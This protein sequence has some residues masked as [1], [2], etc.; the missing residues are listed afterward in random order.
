M[1]QVVEVVHL[2]VNQANVEKFVSVRPTVDAE[3]SKLTG[4]AGAELVHVQDDQ[5][6]LMVYWQTHA[7]V[8]AAQKITAHMQIISDWIGIADQVVS[9]NTAEIRHSSRS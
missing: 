1:P 7:D 6:L 2:R 9:F 4:F 5:W 8:E 3:V